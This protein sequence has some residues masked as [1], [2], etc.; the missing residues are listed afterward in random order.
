MKKIKVVNPL[1]MQS[2][3]LGFVAGA[4]MGAA[5]PAGALA[6]GAIGAGLGAIGGGIA[7][8]RDAAK[9]RVSHMNDAASKARQ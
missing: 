3:G 1:P 6:L 8:R 2:A 5:T 7:A 4:S 9:G